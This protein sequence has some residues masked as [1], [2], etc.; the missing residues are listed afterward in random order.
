MKKIIKKKVHFL[1]FKF[2]NLIFQILF[3]VRGWG[4]NAL[5]PKWGMNGEL[6]LGKD[7]IG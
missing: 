4:G 3:Y 7:R 5:I 1:S 6:K 2:L